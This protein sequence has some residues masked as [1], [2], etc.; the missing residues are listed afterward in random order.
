MPPGTFQSGMTYQ[1][2]V[3][4]GLHLGTNC[5]QIVSSNQSIA[6]F[7]VTGPCTDTQVQGT[8]QAI[9]PG[10]V[11]FTANGAGYNGNGFVPQQ[12]A[13]PAPGLQ[14][15]I[16]PAANCPAPQITSLVVNGKATNVVVLGS[17]GTISA[18][19]CGLT[20]TNNYSVP[21]GITVNQLT[22]VNDGQVNLTY[23]SSASATPTSGFNFQLFQV[24]GT[25]AN[26]PQMQTQ[27]PVTITMNGTM[28]ASTAGGVTC[29]QACSVV[30]GQ[31]IALTGSP[32][33]GTWSIPGTTFSNWA[34]D[35]TQAT[36][37]NTSSNPVTFFWIQAGTSAVPYA[38]SYT[39]NGVQVSVTF[40]AVGPTVSSYAPAF[41]KAIYDSSSTNFVFGTMTIPVMV[42]PPASYTGTVS[43]LQ[44]I[45]STSF[46][47]SGQ[48]VPTTSC[49]P[50]TTPLN[51]A[52]P[53]LDG[54]NPYPFG[55]PSLVRD[56]PFLPLSSAQQQGYTHVT[57]TT[58]FDIYLMWQPSVAGATTFA[59][60]LLY[61]PWVVGAS[62]TYT[63]GTWIP[64]GGATG[65][66]VG[67]AVTNYPTWGGKVPQDP[68]L[69][70]H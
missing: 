20:G 68:N 27:S 55:K 6:T 14:V 43:W 1:G 47:A 57:Q 24:R 45:T 40:Q 70:C 50:D 21:S 63:N 46:T 69:S 48:G 9:S 25:S 19:G 10:T 65:P 30:V 3:I 42:A 39:A 11:T 15:P 52:R 62:G 26:Y 5:P 54:G 38:A 49:T 16:T 8:L 53:W 34:G 67:Q 51:A 36:P 17:S 61:T 33:G 28:I 58:T 22:G 32:A 7:S 2:I 56:T 44:V 59:V 18:F 64:S 66:L 12:G 4:N 23:T 35:G 37:T 29:G 13:T 31:Q 41:T 60:P